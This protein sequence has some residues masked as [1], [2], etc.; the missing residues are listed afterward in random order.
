MRRTDRGSGHRGS[1]RVVYRDD[2]RTAEIDGETVV[3]VSHR[4]RI[5]APA[6]DFVRVMAPVT[7]SPEY[8]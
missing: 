1:Q 2:Q 6:P 4:M 3:G 8:A 7:I 5:W